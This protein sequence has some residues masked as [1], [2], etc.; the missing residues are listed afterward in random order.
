MY[1]FHNLITY[2]KLNKLPEVRSITNMRNMRHF[3]VY[4]NL[5][6]TFFS[7][8]IILH[9]SSC[10][11]DKQSASDEMPPLYP[12]PLT[13]ELNTQGGYIIN[14]VTGDSI[15]PINSLG[16]TVITGLPVAAR[17]KV[18][19]PGS[20]AK[21][22]VIP[23]GKPEVVCPDLNV[24]KIPESL[25]VIPVNKDLLRTFTPGVDTS[26]FVLVNSTGDTVPTGVPLPA[27]GK[28]VTCM[29]PQPVKAS[30]PRRK[31][32]ATINIKYLDS[33]P[34]MN[35]G[36]IRS[37]LMDRHGNLWFGTQN[38]AVSMY[39]GETSTHFT[40]KEGLSNN[41]VRSML[42][43]RHGNLWIGTKDGLSMY[44]G[45]TFTHFTEKE[46]LS[47]NSVYFILE[48]SYGNLLFATGG[49]G[50]S[51]YNGE[52][53]THFTAKE[54]LIS[55][56]VRS[57][58]EDSQGNLW[59]GTEGGGVSMYNG[60][61]FTH[62]TEK[63][64]LSNNIVRSILED[65][66]GNLWFGTYGGG[67]NRYNGETF[68]HFTTKEGL[69]NNTVVSSMEDSQGNLW[70]AT[71]G[72]GVSIYNGETF[73][74]FTENEGLSGNNVRSILE[75][76]HGNIWLGTDGGLSIYKGETF[77]HF[78]E[79]EGL[80][81]NRIFSILEDSHD[82]L[83]FGTRGG[84]VSMYNGETFM[85]FTEKEGL[86]D[87]RIYSILEDSHGNLW[88]GTGAGAS[89]YNGETFTHFTEKEGLSDSYVIPFLEDSHGNLWFSNWGAGV[90][91]YNGKSFTYFTEKEGLIS[92]NV[93]SILEDSYGNLWFVNLG[94]G[95]SMYNGESFTHFT[96]KEG[97]SSNNVLSILEDSHGNLWFGTR[98]EGVSMYNGK[99]FTHFTEKEGL[100]NN[101]V[102]SILEDSNSNI[103]LGTLDG[104]NR[105]VFYPESVS[106]T[107]SS[108]FDS[109]VK[110]DSVN[111]A[112]HN[113][114]IHT[115][116]IQDGLKGMEFS[117]NDVL[118]DSKNRIW[119][120]TDKG[121]SMLDM[122]NFKIPVEP[123]EIL[124]NRIEI[125]EQFT[126]IEME[127]SDQFTDYRHLNES[128]GIGMKFNG[129]ANFNNYPLNLELPYSSNRLLF[130][131]SAID[132]SA[133]HKIRYSHKMEGLND[134]WSKP[135]E[136]AKA[137]YRNLPYGAFTFKVRAIGEAQKWSETFEYTFI[138][139][140]P[141]WHT[142]WARTGYGI[143][144][145]L[146][147]SSIVRWRTAKLKQSQKELEQKIKERT[148][149]IQDKN[150]ELRQQQE[151]LKTI[152][153]ILENQKE[154]LQQ[155]KENLQEQ[156]EE[157]QITLEN[158]KA[159]QSQLIQ[160]EKMASIGQLVAG[161]A[162][163]INNPVTFIS[164]GVDSL[165]TNL[166]EIRQVLDI[167]HK[168]TPDNAEEKLVEIEQ[169]KEKIEYK[170]TIREINKLIDSV[171]TGTERTTEIVKGLRTFSRL[172]EDVLKIADIHEGID[173]T[174][175]LLRN[176]YKERIEIEKHY[177]D[178]PEIEC[179][180]GQLNQVFMNILSNAIDAID[181]KGTITISTSKS[182]GSIRIS[183]KDTGRGIPENIQSKIFEPF[184]TTKEVGQGTGLGLS[185]CHS[186]IEKHRGSTEVKSEVG[187]GC[188]FV[189]ALPVK[190]S[191][192]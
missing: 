175:I 101:T 187:K 47:N 67:V 82:N 52:T 43:D 37:I 118:L 46:G 5:K 188:E 83:W 142:W 86:S 185:I 27:Q 70:F 136:E 165:N 19:D 49:G 77:T 30:P 158:L 14:P 63:E 167:Y 143:I 34:G 79:K 127:I 41:D 94:K 190:Q 16:D 128:I 155:Q 89:M 159:T 176:K 36:T 137:D 100:S 133:P 150:E 125:N 48:D 33:E 35:A 160:S 15:Q 191:K 73:T 192:K 99:T 156:K 129:V 44:N 38:G 98:G 75:D 2:T 179:Y 4:E 104:L 51:I 54:G 181:N 169:L 91:K 95:L 28:I 26:T 87:N 20:L 102:T 162:H 189:I 140:P 3:G 180:P 57:I 68:T 173:S 166:E 121:L 163:E 32:N 113:P 66:H 29:Q 172:D 144:A 111:G 93:Y 55:N 60:E 109:W 145:V 157:L 6:K 174:L 183:I 7:I 139:H 59:F 71:V 64:G 105:L 130:Y 18:I 72:G 147:I 58:L 85:H 74:H 53:F 69:S 110:A 9:L 184:F 116:S 138:I 31:E 141:W 39:N 148:T 92:N 8:T 103:W 186:I 10:N 88:F 50:V 11:S 171:K 80:S 1:N 170:E 17:G 152:N 65:R 124:L 168:I 132:W 134:D 56:D 96:E 131:F 126:G 151:E 122:N 108:L 21:P 78:T 154:E 97:L 117:E 22:K 114:V 120:G 135:T 106:T 177:G 23:A 119:W 123:P 107:K 153:E 182:N 40:T 13:V 164:A 62:F 76:G 146:L 112:N 25:T 178:I 84:G 42:E 24:H 161:I 61:I 149:E 81:D 45:E 90:S 12:P 115:Y